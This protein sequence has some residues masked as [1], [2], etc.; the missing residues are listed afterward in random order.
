[1]KTNIFLPCLCLALATGCTIPISEGG[2]DIQFRNAT[3]VP[4]THEECIGY[5]PASFEEDETSFWLTFSPENISLI[6]E[7]SELELT[8]S[9]EPN[10]FIVEYDEGG[11]YFKIHAMADSSTSLTGDFEY[12]LELPEEEMF[13]IEANLNATHNPDLTEDMFILE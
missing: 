7:G 9:P 5:D 10:G 6:L 11:F 12:R 13:G 4:E 2:W 3:C 8:G 1:M